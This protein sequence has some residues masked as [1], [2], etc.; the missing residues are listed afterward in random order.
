MQERKEREKN[1]SCIFFRCSVTYPSLHQTIASRES[2]F[3]ICLTRAKRGREGLIC[4]SGWIVSTLG[5]HWTRVGL[6][7]KH[8]LSHSVD[9]HSREARLHH[10][11]SCISSLL[12]CSSPLL[13]WQP[14]QQGLQGMELRS[15]EAMK[16]QGIKV[17]RYEVMKYLIRVRV[18]ECEGRRAHWV[19]PI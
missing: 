19:C 3:L 8:S 11:H 12:F 9:G 1:G 4:G 5:V 18:D 7:V 14:W 15:Y 17:R 6:E 2:T 16:Y 10:G 13:H